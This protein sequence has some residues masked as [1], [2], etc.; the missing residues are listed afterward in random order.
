[1][2]PPE[3]P[4]P[5][6]VSL[7]GADQP[8][9][10]PADVAGPTT[11]EWPSAGGERSRRRRPAAL[12]AAIVLVVAIGVGAAFFA[13][14][15]GANH[16]HAALP[17]LRVDHGTF[18]PGR[19]V[20]VVGFHRTAWGID[21]DKSRIVDLRDKTMSVPTGD[22]PANLAAGDGALWLTSKTTRGGVVQR[23]MPG[24]R[25]PLGRMIPF[26]GHPVV[27][28][29]VIHNGVIWEPTK[30]GLSRISVGNRTPVP[31]RNL[32]FRPTSLELVAGSIWA[33]GGGVLAKV[34]LKGPPV[35][36][37]TRL[38]GAGW[39]TG[40]DKT[41]YVITPKGVTKVD[42]RNPAHHTRV[43]GVSVPPDRIAVVDGIL[44]MVYY[45]TAT[46][47]LIKEIDINDTSRRATLPSFTTA[48]T[49]ALATKL[50]AVDHAFW[51][52]VTD[53]RG[54]VGKE[55][56]TITPTR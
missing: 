3:T 54:N 52:T 5:P 14:T 41:L 22:H 7:G 33:S 18:V 29:A 2:P 50:V 55:Q 12:I 36:T 38:R 39:I 31:V 19:I 30:V 48:R 27:P 17:T 47:G 53:G 10:V 4:L 25:S 44:W 9:A 35:A 16:H 40:S 49:Q 28:R 46:T 26:S 45:P 42:T 56:F 1:M 20:S 6:P 23:V 13:A 32:N 21:R 51:L 24:R 37:R 11:F 34:P 15:G 8:T 43:P